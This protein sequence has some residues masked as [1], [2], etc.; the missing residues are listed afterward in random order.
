M[1]LIWANYDLIR[2]NGT[3][4]T[5]LHLPSQKLSLYCYCFRFRSCRFR[6]RSWPPPGNSPAPAGTW[7]WSPWGRGSWAWPEAARSKCSRGEGPLFASW[8]TFAISSWSRG[9]R[10]W[11]KWWARWTGQP[12]WRWSRWACPW[13]TR[14]IPRRSR[15]S[16]PRGPPGSRHQAWEWPSRR[17]QLLW[18][19]YI[20]RGLERSTPNRGQEFES[21]TF[22]LKLA[23][24]F[25]RGERACWI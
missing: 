20:P 16:S 8:V 18:M 24:K 4:V 14:P 22:H 9:E 10:S 2:S 15:P 3:L 23:T 17:Q 25:V 12:G 19:V 21:R 7:A 6:F 11:S 1:Q 5:Y 13:C